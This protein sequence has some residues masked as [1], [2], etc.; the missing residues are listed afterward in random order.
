MKLLECLLMIM[1]LDS[2]ILFVLHATLLF[3]FV[4]VASLMI[5]VFLYIALK[6]TSPLACVVIRQ[7]GE[8]LK[9]RIY[10]AFGLCLFVMLNVLAVPRVVRSQEQNWTRTGIVRTI[11]PTIPPLPT[12]RATINYT[13]SI[14]LIDMQERLLELE[15]RL[16]ACECGPGVAMPI[17]CG[18]MNGNQY[19]LKII[20]K[21]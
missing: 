3:I 5:T 16:D 20:K 4:T 1:N 11:T 17:E 13:I 2:H 7:I 19:Y 21:Q 15:N 8:G 6:V 10:F 18:V 12:L 9:G 14:D